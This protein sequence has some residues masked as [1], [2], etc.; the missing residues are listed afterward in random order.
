VNGVVGAAGLMQINFF[1]SDWVDNRF[2]AYFGTTMQ[3]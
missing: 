2:K 3:Q 1:A